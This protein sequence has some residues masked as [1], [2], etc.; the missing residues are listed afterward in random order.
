MFDM[1]PTNIALMVLIACIIIWFIRT[2]ERAEQL[3]DGTYA[4]TD[5]AL[6][7]A[8]QSSTDIPELIGAPRRPTINAHMTETIHATRA[9]V[10]NTTMDSV[11]AIK[12]TGMFQGSELKPRGRPSMQRLNPQDI[13]AA[14]ARPRGMQTPGVYK[15]NS[16]RQIRPDPALKEGV[17]TLPAISNLKDMAM[18]ETYSPSLANIIDGTPDL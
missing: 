5:I 15:K 9:D 3:T 4:D 11:Q 10:S 8:N 7:T 18:R 6:G 14:T 12:G 2:R 13:L 1:T 17:D 16:N